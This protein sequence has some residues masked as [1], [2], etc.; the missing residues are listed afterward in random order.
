[1][2]EKV[3]ELI[4]RFTP[5]TSRTLDWDFLTASG[6]AMRW[7]EM[8]DEYRVLILADPGAGK[9]FEAQLR[10]RRFKERGKKAFFIRIEAIDAN[11]EAGFEVG[12]AEEFTAWLGSTEEAWFFLDSVDE[13]QLETPRALETAIR[14]FGARVHAARERAHVFITSREDAWQALPDRTLVDQFLPFGAPPAGGNEEINSGSLDPM[15]KVFRLVGLLEDE[16][17][18]FASHYGVSDI[19]G[20]VDSIRRGNLMTLAERPFDLKALIQKWLADGVLSSR[21]EV[22]QRMIELQL[23]P[24]SDTGATVRIDAGKAR[25]GARSLAGAVLLTGKAIICLPNGVHSPDRIDPRELLTDW[26]NAE[27]DTLLRTGLFDDIVYTSV[28]FRHREIRELLSAEWARDLISRPDGRAPVEHLFFRMSYGEQVIV[29]RT[30]PV[31][32][33]LIL[34]DEEVRGRALAL[35]PEIASEG[36][37]PSRLPFA[38][39]QTMLADIV[40]R[41]ASGREGMMDN[42]AI[43]RIAARDLT[44]DTL[45]LLE[46]YSENDDV[47][48]FLGRLVWQGEMIDCVPALMEIA[49]DSRRGKYA[50]IISIRGAMSVGNADQKERIW[51]TIAG[52][53]APLDPEFLAELLEWVE[54]TLRSVELL[55]RTLERVAPIERYKVSDLG[56]ALHNFIDRFVMMA[57]DV[58]DQPLGQLIIGLNDFLD[59]EPYVE[60]GECHV[61]KEFAWLMPAALHAVDRLVAARSAQA[62]SPACIAVMRNM[63]A[64]RFWRESDFSEYKNS[65]SANVRRWKILNDAL[66]WDSISWSRKDLEGTGQS[67]VDDWQISFVGHFWSFGTEDFDRCLAWVRTKGNV[68]DR[69]VALSRCI[70]IYVE[71]GRPEAWLEFLGAAVQGDETLKGALETYL[72]PKPSSAVQ[73]REAKNLVRKRE[74]EARVREEEEGRTDWVR[75]LKENPSLIRRPKETKTGE[76]SQYQI[77]LLNSVI[78]DDSGINWEDRANWRKLISE[79]GE[80]VARAYRDAAVEHW[81]AY[82]PTLRSEG[83]DKGSIPYSLIF[84]MSGLAIE[85]GEDSAFAQRLTADEARHAFRYVTCELNGLP[86]WFESLYNAHPAIGFEAVKKELLWE[87]EYGVERETPNHIL[88]DI[89]YRAPWLHAEVA[90]LILDWLREHDVSNADFLRCC[91]GILAGGRIV[92]ITL[93]ELAA[94]KVH[95]PAC[96]EQRPRWF[97]LWVDSDPT[98]AIPA[99]DRTLSKLPKDEAS[100]LAQEFIVALLNER[101]GTGTRVGA[102]R[103]AHDLKQLY[104]LMHKLIRVADDL[105]RAN[106]GVYSPTLRDHAQKAREALFNMLASV[107]GADAYAAVKTLEM[108]HPEPQYRRWMALRARERATIDADEPAWTV[109]QVREFSIKPT[110]TET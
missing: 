41:I 98:E 53:P 55:M 104:V 88:S 109:P 71:A 29:P 39:R 70:R 38:Q 93:A 68:Q 5:L 67:L 108:E 65:L 89:L 12:T 43:E 64:L 17:K 30:R 31:L 19:T 92:P 28:R 51:E 20:F 83:A 77:Y 24:L 33:W 42:N 84:A 10:T 76:C 22:L 86:S 47:V 45:S 91:L 9:T 61:S 73:E 4:R 66:Y 94:G 13:A 63:P 85:F 23:A 8:E 40:E 97:A 49:S 58:Q 25:S 50:R 7:H 69:L 62:L 35:A 26:S 81:R 15:L 79:F 6:P 34:L 59:R 44:S 46:K 37:D 96:A 21:F 100:A 87:L 72:E 16:I 3:V 1:M 82:R 105:D 110:L 52:H 101:H 99:L 2:K 90:P 11:F 32:A 106:K 78:C 102:Y 14:I 27:I 57:D 48:F 54:P 95:G 80:P 56:Q 18:L 103:N 60:R 74:R 107:P 36:G 75:E